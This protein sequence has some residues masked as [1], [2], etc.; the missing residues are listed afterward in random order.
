MVRYKTSFKTVGASYDESLVLLKKLGECGSWDEV[1]EAAY[2]ENILKKRSTNW[3]GK[4]LQ[5]TKSRYLD[6]HKPLPGGYLLSRFITVA[7][8]NRVKVQSLYQYI[9]ENYPLVD[10]LVCALVAPNLKEYNAFR[11]TKIIYGD[12]LKDEAEEHPEI[13]EWADYTRKKWRRDFYAF[14]RSS[15]LMETHPSVLVKSF[16]VR[17]E[18]FA[19]F[20]YGLLDEDFS[21]SEVFGSHIWIRYFLSEK[22]VM[23]MLSECQVRGW[24][25]W[26]STG[27]ITELTPR[28]DSLE[29][30]IN[31]LE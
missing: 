31:A 18:A 11:L 16:I 1:R 26:R 13:K 24:L 20:L 19:F 22:E 4:L 30:W 14:L 21:P 5:N 3:I 12:F 2:K 8:S 9:C 25:Q 29:D 17:P 10:R 6:V 27:S 7:T 23:G 28:F 15:G